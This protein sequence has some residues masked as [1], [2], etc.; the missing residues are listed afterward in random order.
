M[1]SSYLPDK[2]SSS[3]NSNYFIKYAKGGVWYSS[4][5]KATTNIN[6]FILFNFN[7]FLSN[8]KS[9]A[10]T[11][12]L[13][14]TYASLI[15]IDILHKLKQS[16]HNINLPALGQRSATLR[17]TNKIVKV[18]NAY[19]L[20]IYFNLQANFHLKAISKFSRSS[21]FFI[22]LSETSAYTSYLDIVLPVISENLMT[23][24]LAC[25]LIIFS[26]YSAVNTNYQTFFQSYKNVLI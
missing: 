22:G 4:L 7:I 17:L 5:K 10:L 11:N 21:A 18:F 6:N 8:L 14:S 1:T 24:L 13:F 9:L 16:T 3:F 19:D 12:N 23:N 20:N 2:R 15:N 26:K 25:R